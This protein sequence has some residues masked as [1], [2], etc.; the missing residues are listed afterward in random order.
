MDYRVNP[1]GCLRGQI[2]VPGDKSIS[3][4]VVM[5]GAIAD[6]VTEAEGLLEGADVLA[7]IAAFQ[8]MGVHMEGPDRGHLRIEGVGLR[9]L[10]AP[11]DI[12][13]CGN[14]GTAMRLLAG[15]LAGQEF[16]CTLT[17]DASLRRRPMGRVFAPLAQMG[18][19]IEAE[20]GRAP[21]HIHGRSLQGIHYDLPVASAQVKSAILLAGLYATG[22]T[23]VREPAPTRDHSERMLQG[24]GQ[25]VRVEG[26]QRCL[27]SVGHLRGQSLRVPGDIS[28]AAFFLLGAS[29]AP[30]SDLLLE[31][32][33]INPTRTGIVEILTRMGAR[34]DLLRLREVGGEPVADLRV[35]YAQLRGI[36]IPT[37]LVPLAID[38]FPAIFIAAAAAEGVTRIRGAEEL[39]VKESDRI[40]VMAA[41]LRTLGIA[42]EELAD[43]AIIHGGVL[44]GGEVA[45]HGD[46]RIAMAFAMA[47]L[48]ARE[49][50]RITD[51][52]NVAT[53]FPNFAELARTAGLDLEVQTS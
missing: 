30:K 19:A 11:S 49:S 7:T 26:A 39:R 29:I 45:S 38:E 15:L 25:P 28:S 5:L 24:F 32:V 48:V 20:D 40:A 23:C 41:G 22:D 35:R 4:R 18:A 27:R 14:S 47:G 3:H 52:T 21:L 8:S 17:G 9:G 16:S 34:I 2:S 13:D 6:G 12:I 31:G 44:G 42:V 46:H 50:V 33:G 51:C 10:R 43:G 1:G 36:D 37:R 53:S